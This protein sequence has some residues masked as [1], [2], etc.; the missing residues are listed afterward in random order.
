MIEI[1]KERRLREGT[2][3]AQACGNCVFWLPASG[4]ADDLGACRRLPPVV[5][6]IGS[7]VSPQSSGGCWCGEWAEKGGLR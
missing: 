7:A 4:T 5:V 1:E 2:E 6:A 3:D